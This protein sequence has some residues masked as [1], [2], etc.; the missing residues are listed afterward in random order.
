MHR[1]LKFLINIFVNNSIATINTDPSIIQSAKE[2]YEL[3]K[4]PHQFDDDH[5][6]VYELKE[7]IEDIDTTYDDPLKQANECLV[8]HWVLSDRLDS[9]KVEVFKILVKKCFYQKRWDEIGT[10]REYYDKYLPFVTEGNHFFFSYTNRNANETNEDF[11]D[12]M[13]KKRE[14]FKN[15]LASYIYHKLCK[16]NLTGFWDE[17]N[18]DFGQNIEKV[19]SENLANVFCFVQLIEQNIFSHPGD[20]RKNW[21]YEEYLE[22]KRNYFIPDFPEEDFD[23][24]LLFIIQDDRAL[25]IANPI[26]YQEWITETTDKKYLELTYY[27]DGYCRKIRNDIDRLAFRI[28]EIREKILDHLLNGI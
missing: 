24:T 21:C 13:E 18:I 16:H 5:L 27:K 2:K 28:L 15:N 3:D 12:C 19:L 25:N 4:I 23:D 14:G 6:L 20:D 22:F 1:S 8:K 26:P 9:K 17:N 11:K 7:Y 10:G